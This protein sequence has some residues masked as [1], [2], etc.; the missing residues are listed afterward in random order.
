[1]PFNPGS[2]PDAEEAT[3]AELAST[4]TAG[5]P[6]LPNSDVASVAITSTT[7]STKRVVMTA[8]RWADFDWPVEIGDTFVLSG[9]TAAD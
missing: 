9:S 5:S 4:G 6:Y 2:R 8:Q 7:S 1:M 3:S